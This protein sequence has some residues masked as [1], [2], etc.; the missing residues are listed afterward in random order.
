MLST[1]TEMQSGSLY[2]H[3]DTPAMMWTVN[4]GHIKGFSYMPP[5]VNHERAPDQTVK[6]G[7]CLGA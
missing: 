1:F 7:D 3:V 4:R 5:A 2:Q 6:D